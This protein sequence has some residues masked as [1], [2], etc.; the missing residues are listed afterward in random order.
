MTDLAA[1]ARLLENLIRLGTIAQVD[2]AAARV[3]VQT[4][5]LLTAWLPWLAPA[6]GADREWRPPT[7]G[8]QVLLLSPS[9]VL[10]Q[11]VV[12]RGLF[13]NLIPAN[14]AREGLHRSTY[15]DG[16]VIQYDSTAHALVA[17]IPGDAEITATGSIIASAGEHISLM[18]GG[19]IELSATGDVVITGA[20]VRLN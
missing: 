3:R 17:T 20:T 9:G 5:Q 12:L 19:N 13:S 15:P 16:A 14:G 18:A 6:A 2:V 11:G 1:L 10:A 8:E 7:V 4:G